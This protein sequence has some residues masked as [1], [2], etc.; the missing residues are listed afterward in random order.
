M[1][2]T[3]QGFIGRVLS[4]IKLWINELQASARLNNP[5]YKFSQKYDFEVSDDCKSSSGI[6][7]GFTISINVEDHWVPSIDSGSVYY[8]ITVGVTHGEDLNV[9]R[10]SKKSHNYS[11]ADVEDIV[12]TAIRNAKYVLQDGKMSIDKFDGSG[13]LTLE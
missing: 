11:V 12:A 1:E 5:L 8:E 7:D 4:R 9:V 3:K 2:Q 13:S 6:F 10:K